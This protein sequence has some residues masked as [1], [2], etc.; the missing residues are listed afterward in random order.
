LSFAGEFLDQ[1]GLFLS[2]LFKIGG[3]FGVFLGLLEKFVLEVGFLSEAFLCDG[4]SKGVFLVIGVH[5]LNS[6]GQDAGGALGGRSTGAVT[7]ELRGSN[8]NEAK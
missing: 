7:L 6:L 1:D 3:F 8:C 4:V 2:L 5:L